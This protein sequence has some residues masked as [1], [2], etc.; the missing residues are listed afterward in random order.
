MLDSRK[1]VE[2]TPVEKSDP[3]KAAQLIRAER[4]PKSEVVFLSGSVIV[5][6]EFPLCLPW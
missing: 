4:Y 1:I 3:I 6:P 5:L 2:Q